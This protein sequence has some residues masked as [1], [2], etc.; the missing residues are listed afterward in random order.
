VEDLQRAGFSVKE[1]ISIPLESIPLFPDIYRQ[2]ISLLEVRDLD[3]MVVINATVIRVANRKSLE[4][5]KTFQCSSCG[6]QVRGFADYVNMNK[7]QIP[8]RC[9]NRVVKQKKS[10]PIFEAFNQ[11]RKKNNNNNNRQNN[12]NQN[13]FNQNNNSN[14]DSSKK[15]YEDECGCSR[16][17]PIPDSQEFIDYQEIKLQESFRKI[18]PGN[19]PR[20]IWV[21]LEVNPQKKLNYLIYFT[22]GNLVDRCSPGD[23]IRVSGTLI[24]RWKKVQTG[25]RPDVTWSIL[26]NDIAVQNKER[27]KIF[28]NSSG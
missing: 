21:I 11:L 13:N 18:K 25:S 2:S 26:A 17:D 23:D 6:F 19:I 10:N 9:T 5:A 28:H 15:M 24:R 22:K 7:I 3:R 16:F 1:Y 14:P 4:K 8:P 20:T 12:F 27:G